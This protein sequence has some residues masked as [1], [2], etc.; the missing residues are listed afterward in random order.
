[1]DFIATNFVG[2]VK[3]INQKLLEKHN[4]I[5]IGL[6]FGKFPNLRNKMHYITNID[7][8]KNHM[9]SVKDDKKNIEF[10]NRNN[11]LYTGAGHTVMELGI[12]LSIFLEPQNIITIGWDVENSTTH[13]DKKEGFINWHNETEII[14]K[15]SILFHD[16]LKKHYNINIYKINKNSGIKL[17]VF[18]EKN[19]YIDIFST[20]FFNYKNIYLI[21][22]N[23]NISS[24]TISYINKHI[25]KES[26]VIRFNGD[27]LNLQKKILPGK[28]DI[29]FY[30]SST[31]NFNKFNK[32][33]KEYKNIVYTTLDDELY[34]VTFSNN[35]Q[36][37]KYKL[38]SK[39][40]NDNINKV[41]DNDS[42]QNQYISFISSKYTQKIS[43][44]S[45][46]GILINLIERTN[47]K[48]INLVGFTMITEIG[49]DKR[50]GRWHNTGYEKQYFDNNIRHLKNVKIYN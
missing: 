12:P 28:N 30:R 41:I 11:K 22:N 16:Y 47:Y 27:Y 2:S 45:G 37:N 17:P 39:Y 10:E 34:N 15:F 21:A 32:K 38:K 35:R 44:T 23:P 31:Y 26:L 50:Y 43:P 7:L 18:V 36:N 19:A 29:M 42:N 13:W 9:Q 46:F 8:S 4:T 3:R 40:L 25:N 48:T 5:N 14:N 1:M 24:E 49:L 6:N 33:Y 20:T